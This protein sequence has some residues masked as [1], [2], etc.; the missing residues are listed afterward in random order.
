MHKL[1]AFR[2]CGASASLLL[3]AAASAVAGPHIDGI[4]PTG[5]AGHWSGMDAAAFATNDPP[6][7]FF[8]GKYFEY[9][10]QFYLRKKD[11]REALDLFE[12]AGFWANKVAQYNA[13]LMYYN[14]IGVPVDKVRGVAWLGIAAE[15]HDDLAVRALEVAYASLNA[16]E[17]QQA[18]LTWKQLDE[19]YGDAVALPRALRRFN[20]E[21]HGATGSHL[22]FLA[23]LQV[24]ETGTD[25]SSLG[26]SGFTYYRGQGNERDAL[27]GQIT[28]HVTVGAVRP[29]K[30]SADALRDASHAPLNI[31][32]GK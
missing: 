12:L 17:K 27:I 21:A 5:G 31:P 19:K 20:V 30:V 6:G 22:G 9:K 24:Y 13:G 18:N 25:G 10:A 3:F 1:C 8:P 23:N 7:N 29:L 11:Y 4:G 15:E 2:H 14:G 16:E 28:G 32:A 26:Q